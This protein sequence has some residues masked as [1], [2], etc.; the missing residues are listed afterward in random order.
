[1]LLKFQN[2]SGYTYTTTSFDNAVSFTIGA[3]DGHFN[4]EK[5]SLTD[6][7]GNGKIDIVALNGTNTISYLMNSASQGVINSSTF[8]TSTSAANTASSN[9]SHTISTDF[10]GD[11]DLDFMGSVVGYNGS[12]FYKNTSSIGAPSVAHQV[13][14]GSSYTAMPNPLDI[15]NDGKI[16]LLSFYH[17]NDITYSMEN[18]NTTP[19]NNLSFAYKPD[20]K[21]LSSSWVTGRVADLDGDGKVDAV[22]GSGYQNA[23]IWT[24]KNN[25]AYDAAA[26]SFSW[27]IST[28]YATSGT[29]AVDIRIADFDGDGKDDILTGADA[30]GNLNLFP[31]LSTVGTIT[32]GSRIDIASSAGTG[33]MGIAVGDL[34][35][36]GKP[37]IVV[38]GN[39]RLVYLENISSGSGNFSFASPVLLTTTGAS[40]Y[41][42]NLKD[43]DGDGFFD[44][45]G[46]PRSGGSIKVFR[47]AIGDLT[48]FYLKNTGS[49]I[50]NLSDWTSSSNGIG[51]TSPSDF[52]SD[53]EFVLANRASYTLDNNLTLNG[54]LNLNGNVLTI[55]NYT[56]TSGSISGNSPTAYIKTNGSGK[57]K[58]NLSNSGTKVFP[59][60]NSAYNP[61]SITNNSGSADDFSVLVLDEVY[62][63]GGNGTATTVPRVRRTWDISKTNANGGAGINFTF[64]W[65]SG[66]EVSLTDPR[67]Y[68]YEGGNWVQANRSCFF[69]FYTV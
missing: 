1:M 12:S 44:I 48:K 52:G 11:G 17:A 5:Y 53:K 61:V 62:L 22:M 2:T 18:T 40:L 15:N 23:F 37:D 38:S 39:S 16:D 68:H 45:I 51:G 19:A 20:F 36:D 54:R 4:S 30:S 28:G 55:A 50:Y 33:L 56:L 14:T 67:L 10:D 7:D 47:N 29:R 8:T 34:N 26:A 41:S 57:F 43:I 66:E 58:M 63:N 9:Y 21:S 64:N 65:N 31:N 6:I 13:N 24:Y 60:G 46:A 42:L 59:V 35:N 25:T 69:Y 49:T 27:A 32:L 3:F